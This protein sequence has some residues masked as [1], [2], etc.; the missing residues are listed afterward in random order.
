MRC[1]RVALM[2]VLVCAPLVSVLPAQAQGTVADYQRAMGLRDKYQGLAANMPEPATWIEKTPRFWYRKSVK[3][4]N[5]F[6]LGRRDDAGE[7]AGV[8]SRKDG[9]GADQRAHAGETVHRRHAAVHDLQLR[10]RRARDRD[11]RQPTRLAVHARGLHAAGPTRPADVAGA[12]AAADAAAGLGGPVRAEFDVNGVE[13]K[14][15][16]DGKLEALVNNYNVAIR[17]TGK[18]AVTLLSI[19]GS[20]GGYYDPE[21]DRLV[22][23]LEEDRRLQGQARLPTLRALRPV[24]ARGSAAAEALDAAVRQARRRPRRRAAGAL[25]RRHQE[26]DH[27]RRC[28]VPERVRQ[29][30]RSSGGRTAAP[31]RSNTTSAATR[32]T[33][34]SRSTRPPARRAR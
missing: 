34:S 19:D 29:H 28:V 13:P 22:A 9:G 7:T 16:P 5:E 27:R 33:A 1:S 10:R 15:S 25:P 24:V 23:R 6:V 4:G 21:L 17:E 20:E 2:A 3:G 11:H 14:K 26:A 30:C 32:S 8:R 31:S 12:A 18:P